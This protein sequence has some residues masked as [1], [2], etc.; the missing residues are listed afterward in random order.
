MVLMNEIQPDAAL[1]AAVAQAHVAE[2]HARSVREEWRRQP[3]SLERTDAILGA[4]E[5]LRVAM[6]PLRS[7]I[8]RLV[9]EPL[10]DDLER[11][12]REQSARLQY[13]RR[14]L[15]KMDRLNA[16][17]PAPTTG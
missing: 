2:L 13:E 16:L 10:P 3:T 9:W 14:Q 15:R 1:L 5:G 17:R 7:A 12:L 6:V 11:R 4:L 8:G